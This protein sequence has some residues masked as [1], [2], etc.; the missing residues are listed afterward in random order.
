MSGHKP[1]RDLKHKVRRDAFSDDV[2]DEHVERPAC[3]RPV[4]HPGYFDGYCRLPSGHKGDC[5]ERA[6]TQKE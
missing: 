5:D 1:W 6:P 2:G 4:G 3:M